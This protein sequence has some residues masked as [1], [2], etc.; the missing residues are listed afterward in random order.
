MIPRVYRPGCAIIMA[1]YVLVGL[2]FWVGTGRL[3]RSLFHVSILFFAIGILM[4][5]WELWR[6]RKRR[7]KK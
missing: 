2:A 7:K 4:V 1:G 3:G 6:T 5:I